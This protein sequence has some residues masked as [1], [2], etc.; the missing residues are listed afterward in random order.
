MESR[1]GSD[2]RRGLESRGHQLNLMPD[3]GA[4][5]SEMMIKVDPNTG[6]LHGAADPRRDGYAIGW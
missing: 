4:Q 2:V 1:F 5:G 3:W 6:A